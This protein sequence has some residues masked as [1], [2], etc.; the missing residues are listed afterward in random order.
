MNNTEPII[1]NGTENTVVKSPGYIGDFDPSKWSKRK[2]FIGHVFERFV[3][4]ISSYDHVKRNGIPGYEPFEKAL[5][6]A[7]RC[8]I[9][10]NPRKYRPNNPARR[11]LKAVEM[12]FYFEFGEIPE[13]GMY[14]CVG[15]AA[16]EYHGVDCFFCIRGTRSVALID[17][18]ENPEKVDLRS[19]RHIYFR[20]EDLEE[21]NLRVFA[22]KVM[23]ALMMPLDVRLRF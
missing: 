11:M 23:S 22:K 14:R 20:R 4:G 19:Q 3:L 5:Q 7:S 6:I 12:Q 1:E 18:T 15:T 13:I 10:W 8:H 2:A 21:L 17:L 16:D 9:H